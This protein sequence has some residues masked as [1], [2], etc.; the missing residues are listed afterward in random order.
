MKKVSFFLALVLSGVIGAFAVTS[1][2]PYLTLFAR[3][4]ATGIARQDGAVEAEDYPYE[5]RDTCGLPR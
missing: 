5:P 3:V 2:T 1:A 4:I